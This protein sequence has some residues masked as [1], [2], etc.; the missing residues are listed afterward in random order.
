MSFEGTSVSVSSSSRGEQLEQVAH[1]VGLGGA[2]GAQ[3]RHRD[4]GRAQVG[5]ALAAGL[6]DA[7]DPVDL[8]LLVRAGGGGR[9]QGGGEE[10]ANQHGDPPEVGRR[11]EYR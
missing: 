5:R 4:G 9:D 8:T 6:D 11:P 10:N 3:A 1:G 2:L 7:A